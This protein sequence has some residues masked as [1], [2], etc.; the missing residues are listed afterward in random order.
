MELTAEQTRRFGRHLVIPEVG[1]EGQKKLMRAK[2]LLIGSGG[3][4]CP[5]A[6]YLTAAGIGHL[7]IADP[8]IVD[9]S[10]LQRQV[11]HFTSDI[12]KRKVESAKAKLTDMNP[13]CHI[14]PLA[15]RVTAANALELAREHD[16][17]IDGTD[18]FGTRYLMNDAC[19][20]AGKPNIYGAVYRFE[21]QMMSILPGRGA[22]YRCLFPDPPPPGAVPSCA[23][24]GV[25]GVLPGIIGILQATEAIKILLG[26]GEPLSGRLLLFSALDMQ[27]RE[28]KVKRR[29][30]CAVCG[31]HPVITQLAEPEVAC[32]AGPAISCPD[33]ATEAGD[34]IHARDA[35]ARRRDNPSVVLVDVREAS[36]LGICRIEHAVHVPLSR[37]EQEAERLDPAREMIVFCHHGAR[38]LQATRWMKEQGFGNVKS[39]RGGID[40]WSTDVDASVPRY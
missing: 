24:A 34:E 19:V 33:A 9:E 11:L 20:M 15:E 12:G 17:V 35:A 23:E 37:L 6:L 10:N 31:E 3:L 25:L 28:V 39:M 32:A 16:I 1:V 13:H 30:D 8:D 27:F 40:A 5:A 38:S 14:R 2:V 4:G 29:P 21:G 22:C 7:T 18:N 36:E 26:V